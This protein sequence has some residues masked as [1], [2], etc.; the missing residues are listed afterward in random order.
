[1]PL[2]EVCAGSVESAL[3]ANAAKA[4]RI[5]LCA[6]LSVGGLTPSKGMIH[7]VKEMVD[8]PVYV[9]IRPRSGDFCYS[10]LEL[11]Q[12]K[13]DVAFCSKMGCEG[14]VIGA[15][16]PDRKIH[17]RMTYELMQEAGY[18]DVTFHKAF[19]ETVNPFEALDTLRELGIQRVLTSGG[20]A[21]AL[22]GYDRLGE[23][24]EEADDDLIIM[25][26]GGIRSENIKHLHSLEAQEYHS[27]A[28]LPGQKHTSKEE[29]KA[30]LDCLRQLSV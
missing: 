16:T 4:D 3:N 14:V 19:D 27:A 22:A 2:L 29:V 30:M 20:A 8:I 10:L 15:L 5:E 6:E 12:M 17:E 25:P 7:L 24:I 9:L 18:M 11:E 1:M 28:L 21:T 13:E 26:G 23:L